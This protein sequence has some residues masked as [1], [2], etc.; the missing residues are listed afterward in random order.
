MILRY[1]SRQLIHN[2]LCQRRY[3]LKPGFHVIA[4]IVATAEKMAREIVAI[5]G[6]HMIAVIAEKVSRRPGLGQIGTQ[7][8]RFPNCLKAVVFLHFF[9]KKC[10]F[11]KFSVPVEAAILKWVSVCI[12]SWYFCCRYDRWRVVSTWSLRSLNFFFTDRS[13]HENRVWIFSK[14]GHGQLFMISWGNM[15]TRN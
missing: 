15:P 1:T 5:D 12:A 3:N 14:V 7:A 8:E 11:N 9:H 6:F 10:K 13:D 4:T 2:H